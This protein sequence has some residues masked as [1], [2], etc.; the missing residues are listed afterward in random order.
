MD[1]ALSGADQK[2][3]RIRGAFP[4]QSG[5]SGGLHIRDGRIL[6]SHDGRK[7]EQNQTVKEFTPR[8]GPNN[9]SLVSALTPAGSFQRGHLSARRQN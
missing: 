9:E 7:T 3:W 2:A 6:K 1:P 8:R 5:F 4:P